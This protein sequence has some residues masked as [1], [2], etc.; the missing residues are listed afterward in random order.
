M[1]LITTEIERGIKMFIKL[2]VVNDFKNYSF[3]VYNDFL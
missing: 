3:F 1:K 2:I